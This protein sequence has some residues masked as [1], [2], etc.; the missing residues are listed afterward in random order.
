MSIYGVLIVKLKRVTAC[1]KSTRGKMNLFVLSK[2]PVKA[3]EAHG[4]KHVVKMVLEACQM[5]YSAHWSCE[6]PS[7]LEE[8]SAIRLATLQRRLSVPASMVDAPEK[9][10]GGHFRPVHLHHPCTIWVRYCI[11]NY[12]WAA[13]LALAL[14]AEYEFRYGK[15][16]A[17]KA[18]AVWLH[19]NPPEIRQLP[20]MGFAIAM[21][22]KFRVKGV[23]NSY[24]KFYIESKKE[25]GLTTYTRR[26][27][28]D[29]LHI[30]LNLA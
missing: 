4:D 22:P 28:P 18:H 2:D 16:H 26:A 3:A 14:A 13:E 10:S 24:I 27:V 25:R 19:E 23:V 30:T 8:R 5:L 7:L 1:G 29:F 11:G 21:D 9:I 6:H 20:R 12:M 15:I 17:C